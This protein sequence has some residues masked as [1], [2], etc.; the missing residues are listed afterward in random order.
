MTKKGNKVVA[1]SLAGLLVL[2]TTSGIVERAYASEATQPAQAIIEF[3]DQ[4]LEKS[5]RAL[6]GIEANSTKKLTE[7]DLNNLER[8]DLSGTSVKDISAL[9][10]AV[11]LKE[12]NLS[13]NQIKDI[14][15]LSTLNKLEKLNLSQN[16]VESVAPIKNLNS[17]KVLNLGN[18]P[19]RNTTDFS[20]MTG[21]TELELNSTNVTSIPML[22]DNKIETLNL[23][24]T[25][26]NNLNGIDKYKALKVLKASNTG[27]K[28]FKPL[29]ELTTLREV[30]ITNNHIQD[31]TF[32][33]DIMK[34][35]TGLQKLSATDSIV[36]VDSGAGGEIKEPVKSPWTVTYS[37]NEYIKVDGST[38]KVTK[39]P[40]DNNP[41]EVQFQSQ[42][43]NPAIE[44]SGKVKIKTTKDNYNPPAVDPASKTPSAV[45]P[46]TGVEVPK[47]S[48]TTT[49]PKVS[50]TKDLKKVEYVQNS[51]DKLLFTAKTANGDFVVKKEVIKVGTEADLTDNILSSPDGATV[52]SQY[53]P[54]VSVIGQYEGTVTV[55]FSNGDE[56]TIKVPI[57]VTADGQPSA[58]IGTLL[59]NNTVS[60][61]AAQA[62]A[63]AEKDAVKTGKNQ[64]DKRIPILAGIALI[65]GIF[66]YGVSK[67]KKE[68]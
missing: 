56:I 17:L 24:S 64:T 43:P 61:E 47:T 26:L 5:I 12:L 18:N 9:K 67:E 58:N 2:S 62:L 51:T 32:I 50:Q 23:D 45:K 33:A 1:A 37:G 15:A 36:E 34:L 48:D 11:N 19:I 53:V 31:G 10:Y 60:E 54:D 59:P 42:S 13:N 66:G 7:A 21:L 68:V 40:T 27:I 55:K 57:D 63:Q 16:L 6:T 8:L 28:D 65:A 38:L 3:S 14:S 46:N 52:V 30:S 49:P 44:Y 41:I 20:S 4:N 25:K 35:N 29:K 22:Q 39:K